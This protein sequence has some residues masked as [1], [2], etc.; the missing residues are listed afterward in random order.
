[1][2]TFQEEVDASLEP[3]FQAHRR[4]PR[5]NPTPCGTGRGPG[6]V[7]DNLDPERE[8]VPRS[9]VQRPSFFW[10]LSC[11]RSEA[12]I[13]KQCLCFVLTDTQHKPRWHDVGSN[14]PGLQMTLFQRFTRS[15]LC[16]TGAFSE[17]VVS[18][19]CVAQASASA[20]RPSWQNRASKQQSH[21]CSQSEHVPLQRSSSESAVLPHSEAETL[22]PTSE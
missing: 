13:A 3:W 10:E 18:R 19:S 2:I 20:K 6:T 15:P 22:C 7:A 17:P 1:M 4:L 11:W 21:C 12:Q 16:A 14:M 5:Q 8:N 9:R